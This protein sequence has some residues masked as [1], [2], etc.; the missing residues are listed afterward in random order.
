MAA[1]I[2][3]IA[4]LPAADILIALRAP[5]AKRLYNH[6]IINRMNDIECHDGTVFHH[7]DC[8]SMML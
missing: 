8:Q 3:I 1:G 4:N 5:I 2:S 6:T 7:V